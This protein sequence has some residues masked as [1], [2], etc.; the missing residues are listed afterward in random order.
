MIDSL[1]NISKH[2]EPSLRKKI[3]ASAS[4]RATKKPSRWS[5]FKEKV[6]SFWRKIGK[7]LVSM[8]PGVGGAIANGVGAAGNMINGL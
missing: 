7:P 5:R 1:R 2:I 4:L 3:E 6:S 8:I